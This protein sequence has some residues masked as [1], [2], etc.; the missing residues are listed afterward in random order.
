MK[1][2]P[3]AGKFETVHPSRHTG[4][5]LLIP[6]TIEFWQGGPK[7]LHDRFIYTRKIIIGTLNASIHESGRRQK[8]EIEDLDELLSMLGSHLP[9]GR[10][11]GNIP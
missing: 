11:R 10:K 5:A 4:E 6:E 8:E 2:P 7:W 1:K 9:T 3:N